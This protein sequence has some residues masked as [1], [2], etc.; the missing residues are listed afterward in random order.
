MSS[1]YFHTYNISYKLKTGTIDEDN[2]YKSINNIIEQ[3]SK[4]INISTQLEFKDDRGFKYFNNFK[5]DVLKQEKQPLI[6]ARKIQRLQKE[7]QRQYSCNQRIINTQENRSAPCFIRVNNPT[8]F[9]KTGTIDEDNMAWLNF[10][11]FIQYND[12]LE[13]FDQN[14]VII[15]FKCAYK[16]ILQNLLTYY[17]LQHNQFIQK[18]RNNSQVSG[19]YNYNKVL[20]YSSIDF[21]Q[22]IYCKGFSFKRK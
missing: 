2:M 7:I 5:Y 16:D 14:T 20:P 13:Y 9:S 21:M 6:I 4:I 19:I 15:D 22:L 11:I 12:I 8:T 3:R 10:D 1:N 18:I 17:Y